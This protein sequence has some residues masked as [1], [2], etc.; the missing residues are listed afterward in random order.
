MPLASPLN[1]PLELRN[2]CLPLDDRNLIIEDADLQRFLDAEPDSAPWIRPMIG[3]REILRS[4][5]RWCLWLKD[6]PE[7]V[8]RL[9]KI[10]ERIERCRRF[11]QRDECSNP[12]TALTPHLFRETPYFGRPLVLPLVASEGRERFPMAL[13]PEGSVIANTC[14][15]APDASLYHFGIASSKMHCVWLNLVCGRLQ[16]RLRYSKTLCWNA[17]PWPKA[18]LEQEAEISS[19]AQDVINARSGL[20][21]PLGRMY[22]KMPVSLRAVHRKLDAA[23][24]SLYGIPE[25]ASDEKRLRVLFAMREALLRP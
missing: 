5:R 25:T 15:F 18:D 9:P 24:D 13:Y 14:H 6:A 12:K 22:Q 16:S 4:R 10:A 1:A 3:A 23:V 7:S 11:R 8:L 19:L 2:G 20:R 17:F 21:V